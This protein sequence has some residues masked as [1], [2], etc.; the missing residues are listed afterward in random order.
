[1]MNEKL[2][3]LGITLPEAPPKGGVYTPCV[4]FGADDKLCYVSGCGPN[5]VGANFAGKLGKDYTVEQGQEAAKNC[6]LNVLAVLKDEIGDLNQVK[7]CVK[8]LVFIA[9]ADD[10]Y[11]QPEVANGGS[12]LIVDLMG[13]GPA[14]SAIGTNTLPGNIPVE[15]EAI[16]ELK[17]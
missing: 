4:R 14:R 11:Q 15:I 12:Q 9:S 16:F 17:D 6:M 2:K 1:M 3:E 10:F 8:L 7:K 13:V 5:L